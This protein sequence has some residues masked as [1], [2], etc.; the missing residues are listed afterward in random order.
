LFLWFECANVI[1]FFLECP[2]N[3]HIRNTLFLILQ[4]YEAIAIDIILHGNE[5][6]TE[7]Q[8]VDIFTAVQTFIRNS[9]RF[10]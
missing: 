3:E 8:N 5:N 4:I 6:L 7:A 9:H 2:I 10:D 1:H